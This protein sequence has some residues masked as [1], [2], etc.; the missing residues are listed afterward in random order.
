MFSMISKHFSSDFFM[1]GINCLCTRLN[2]SE[3]RLTRLVSSCLS[4]RV[5]L[6]IVV[7][8]TPSELIRKPGNSVEFICTHGKTDY[9][10]MLWYRQSP[11]Q[12]DLGLIGH[13]NYQT[14]KVESAFQEDFTSQRGHCQERLSSGSPERPR[15][16]RRVLLRC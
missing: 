14:I 11:G 8:Q 3:K 6:G 5:S 7:H 4:P 15:E 12:R 16:Q 13:V 9:R 2:V 1:M 10:M